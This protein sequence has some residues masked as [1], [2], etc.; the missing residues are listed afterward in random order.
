MPSIPFVL[1][2][3]DFRDLFEAFPASF[4]RLLNSKS[5]VNASSIYSSLSFYISAAHPSFSSDHAFPATSTRL[6]TGDNC[7]SSSLSSKL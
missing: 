5:Q 3:N 2:E 7:E 4:S 6:E 1:P